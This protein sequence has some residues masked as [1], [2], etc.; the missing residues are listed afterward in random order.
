MVDSYKQINI[1][2]VLPLTRSMSLSDSFLT[3]SIV[4]GKYTTSTNRSAIR[5]LV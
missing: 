4:N 1:I 3:K 5:N 2:N